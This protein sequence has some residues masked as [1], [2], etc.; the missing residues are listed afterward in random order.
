MG[1]IR[2]ESVLNLLRQNGQWVNFTDE[3]AEALRGLR[4]QQVF[5]AGLTMML[6]LGTEHN[7]KME[8]KAHGEE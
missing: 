8:E 3:P 6:D 5:T 7:H 2:C 4:L 1:N